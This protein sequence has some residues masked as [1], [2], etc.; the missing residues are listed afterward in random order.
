MFNPGGSIKDRTALN[1]LQ[2]A[3]ERGDVRE[4]TTIVESSSGNL[5]IEN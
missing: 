4:G 2:R 3:I 5:A 1:M